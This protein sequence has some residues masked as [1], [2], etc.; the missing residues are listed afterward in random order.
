MAEHVL[1]HPDPTNRKNLN[2]LYDIIK[3]DA[4]IKKLIALPD[5]GKDMYENLSKLVLRPKN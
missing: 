4:I 2:E 1:N 5:R 3:E